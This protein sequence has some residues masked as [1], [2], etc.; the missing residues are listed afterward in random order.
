MYV[1]FHI[2]EKF[3]HFPILLSCLK[4]TYEEVYP[5]KSLIWFEN[6]VLQLF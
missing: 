2:V 6:F 1:D 5:N 3:I 4:N